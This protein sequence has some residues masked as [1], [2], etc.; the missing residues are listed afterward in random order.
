M[1]LDIGCGYGVPS[2]WL[3]ERFEDLFI[4]GI[5]P[6]PE[7]VRVAGRVFGN[8]GVVGCRAAPDIPEAPGK[9][10]AAFLLD[11]IHFLDD[12]ALYLTF[13]RL[14]E[15]VHPDALLVIRAVVPPGDGRYSLWWKIDVL[16]MRFADVKAYHRTVSVIE[17]MLRKAG[18]TLEKTMLSGGNQESVWLVA[19]RG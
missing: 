18:F 5:D 6:D 2:C 12:A 3:L 11:I 9:A 10:D 4:Y 7:R 17:D 16:R 14:R 19:G 8:R 15:A 1:A 13:E